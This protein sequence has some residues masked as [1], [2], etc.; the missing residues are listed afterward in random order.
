MLGGALLGL[1]IATKLTPV[2]VVP[3][4]VRRAWQHIVVAAAA[5]IVVVYMPHLMTVGSRVIGFLPGYLNQQGYSSGTGFA[6]IS[7]VAPGKLAIVVAGVLLA[8][9]ALAILKFG[10]PDQPWRGGVLMTAA[11]LVICTPEFQWYALLL[12]MLVALDGRP[13]WL[14]LAAGGYLADNRHL[15]ATLLLPHAQFVGYAGGAAVVGAFALARRYSWGIPA[16]P[17]DPLLSPV[18]L[19]DSGSPGEPQETAGAVRGSSSRGPAPEAR[20]SAAQDRPDAPAGEE[21]VIEPTAVHPRP[22]ITIG[23]DGAPAFASSAEGSQVLPPA[24][25]EC[26]G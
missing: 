22:I 24:Y 19:V 18:L 7:V 8:A 6:I 23:T 1:A 10:D 15:T 17:P 2:L 16:N 14:A 21:R 25:H 4:I 12:V 11:A 3:G 20:S 26:I 13:E 5:A 9:I